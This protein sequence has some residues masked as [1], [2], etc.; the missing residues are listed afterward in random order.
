MD[1]RAAEDTA[2][3]QA[4]GGLDRLYPDYSSRRR[5]TRS[6][7]LFLV[8]LSLTLILG[9]QF[10]NV[11]TGVILHAL[12]LVV[13]LAVVLLRIMATVLA[14]IPRRRPVLEVDAAL[15]VYT[16]LC[17]LYRESGAVPGLARAL[18]RLDYPAELLDVKLV[19]EA[20]DAATI[21]AARAHAPA[22]WDLVLVPSA[23]PRTKPKAMNY[24]LAHARGSFVAIYDAEDEPHPQQL[25]AA[26]AAFDAGGPK[27]GCVQAPLLIDNGAQSWL[28]RQFAAE[29]AVHFLLTLP[30][31]A[32]L[33]LPLPL[34]G[35]SNHFRR[36]ALA[37]A[38]GW[39]AFNV[40]EDADLGYRLSRRGWRVDTI[41]PPTWEEAPAH[42]WPWLKQRSRWIKG[43]LQTWLVLMRHPIRTW[44]DLGPQGFW[45]MQLGLGASLA[46]SFVHLPL[47]VFA[48]L[49]V[50]VPGWRL[51]PEDWTLI[52]AGY[53][54]ALAATVMAAI[55]S[56]QPGHLVAALTLP[57]YWPLSSIAALMALFDWLIR[58][59][60]W[61]KTEHGSPFR[62]APGWRKR[63][64]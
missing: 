46:A 9:L 15:P 58:P 37:D 45:A 44:R 49:A 50:L 24:A 2:L 5:F 18:T 52:V 51:G 28:A 61:A 63:A 38:G 10:A 29:Y 6:Q 35:T 36:E 59:Q 7:I 43:H 3:D 30:F 42:L 39:D 55:L 32:R 48:G 17:P 4:I 19:M 54:S 34:G 16:L 14:P 56:R 21:A 12:A 41:T 57:F 8:A 22:H 23:Q 1:A 13:F 62:K 27:L 26:L 33:G 53:G 25:R 47:M 20:D 11:A 40:T 64:P 31:L 60:H